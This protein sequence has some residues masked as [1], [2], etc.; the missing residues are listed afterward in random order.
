MQI[1]FDIMRKMHQDFSL[2]VVQYQLDARRIIR[3]TV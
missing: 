2:V 1:I 3:C